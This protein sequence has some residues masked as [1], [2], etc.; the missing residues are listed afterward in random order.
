MKTRKTQLG[1]RY[2][3]WV[4]GAFRPAPRPA[5]KPVRLT[6]AKADSACTSGSFLGLTPAGGQIAR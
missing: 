1:G 2:L 5:A 4:R 6:V 3:A